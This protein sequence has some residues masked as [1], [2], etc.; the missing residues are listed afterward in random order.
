[1]EPRGVCAA[2]ALALVGAVS[3]APPTIRVVPIARDGKLFVSFELANGFTSD[4]RDVIRSGLT[5]TLTYDVDLRIAVPL[6]IDRT[7]DS[8]RI[9]AR[10][11]YDNLTRQH[12]LAFEVNGRIQDAKVTED[13]Q[14]VRRWLTVVDRLPLFETSQLEPNREYYVRVRAVARPTS[15]WVPWRWSDAAS[16]VAKF[17]FIP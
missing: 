12:R 3:D 11:E 2:L 8:A 4:L 9:T 6:W 14:L 15:R 1:M 7:I 10:V 5:T 13:E 16:G 17:T